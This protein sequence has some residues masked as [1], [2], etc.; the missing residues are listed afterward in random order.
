MAR[1]YSKR[2]GPLP[3]SGVTVVSMSQVVAGPFA[4]MMLADLGANVIKIEAIGR[5]DRA[6]QIQPIPEYFNSL[7]RNKRSVEINVKDERGQAAVKRLVEE[8]DVFLES[9]KPGRI[10]NYNLSYSELSTVNPRLIYCSIS[11]FGR[12]SPYENVAAWDMIIQAM[13]GFMSMN[14]VPDGPPLW[15]GLPSGDLAASMYAIQS[16]LAALH[17]REKGLIQGDWIEVPMLDAA[18]SWLCCRAGYTFATGEPFPRLG[19]RH[20]SIAPFGLFDCSDETI[21]IAA[22]TPTLWEDF[23]CVLGADELVKN[24]RFDTIESRVDNAEELNE[25]IESHLSEAPAANWLERLHEA[26]VPAGPVNDT[27]SV[28]EDEHVKQRGLRRT[29]QKDSGESATVVDHPIHFAELGT[30]LGQAP[31]GLGEST[32]RVMREVGFDEEEVRALQAEG[33]I[34]ET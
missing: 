6:R 13:S 7:N 5:G 22:G 10:D 29:I 34:G 4:T 33:V 20:P 16:I 2:D 1:G 9:N 11:G 8:A 32:E 31:D 21:A 12:D 23:C 24:D 18:I 14:G 17:A 28:W 15:S 30:R 27:R 25:I 3:L 19:T 26:G